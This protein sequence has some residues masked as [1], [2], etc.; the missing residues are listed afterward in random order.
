MKTIEIKFSSQA[1]FEKVNALLAQ[2][3]PE[4]D[5]TITEKNPTIDPVSLLSQES[6][7]EEWDS[8]EDKRWDELL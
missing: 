8:E 6:L 4:K 3:K 7:S 2:I 1:D 5:F